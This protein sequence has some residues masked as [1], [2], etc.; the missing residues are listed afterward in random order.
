[1]PCSWDWEQ[2]LMCH[3]LALYLLLH[4]VVYATYSVLV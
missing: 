2:E 3:C 1:M 4:V